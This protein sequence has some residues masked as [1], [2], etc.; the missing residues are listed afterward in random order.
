[1]TSILAVFTSWRSRR[2]FLMRQVY[3]VNKGL[4]AQDL[5]SMDMDKS[6]QVSMLEFVEFMLLSMG[7]V[8]KSFLELI[9]KQFHEFDVDNNGFL[10][11]NDLKAIVG[12]DDRRIIP[13][14]FPS[15][16]LRAFTDTG[17]IL[18]L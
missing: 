8:D 10:D 4:R 18:K 16:S 12:E 5:M 3:K 17:A 14:S 7:R 11:F 6:G 2:I 1:M 13:D 15:H 9:R